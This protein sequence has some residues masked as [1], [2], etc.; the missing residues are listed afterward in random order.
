LVGKV[1]N[2]GLVEVPMGISLRD[3]IYEVGGGIP[4]GRAFKAVQTGGPS[5]GCIPAQFLELPVDFEHLEEAGSIMGSGG[6]IV[7]DET[8]CMVDVA[9]Y[10][11]DF[12]KDESCGKCTPCREGIAHMLDIMTCITE[13]RGQMSDLDA[14]ESLALTIK[15]ASLCGLGQTAPNPV[16]STLKYFR[17]EYVAHIQDKHCPAGV[18]STLVRGTCVNACPAGVDIPS[19]V[20]LVAQGRYAEALEIH[21]Q[22][23]PFALVCGRVCPAFCEDRCRRAELNQPI[24]IRQ[25]KRFMADHEIAKPWTPKREAP[26]SEKVAVIGAGPGGLTAA[27]R[28]AQKGYPVTVFEALPVAGGMLIVGIP[29]YRLPP[30]ILNIEIDN[31]RRAGVEIK[32]NTA[33]GKD[34]SLDDL[35]RQGYKAII[36]AIGAHKSRKLGIS[37]ED[38][39]GVYPGTQ[40]LRDIALDNAPDLTGKRI[41]VVGGGD[42]AIDAVRSAWRLGATEVHLV[43]R[44][45][46][47]DMPAYEEEIEAAEEEGVQFHF[48]TNP[49]RV[50]GNGRM[51]GVEIIRQELTEFDTSGRR[52]PKAIAG[53]EFVLDVD[54]LIPAIGQDP[55]L[56]GLEDEG[57]ETDRGRTLIVHDGLATNKAGVF[58]CG[59]AVTGPATVVQAIGTGNLVA[60]QVDHYLRTGEIHRVAVKPGYTVVDQVFDMEEYFKATRPDTP[61]LPVEERRGTFK[62]VEQSFDELAIREEC[63]RCIRCDR[64]W[65]ET[66]DL[67]AVPVSDQVFVIDTPSEEQT[68]E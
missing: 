37:G 42:V 16:L 52:R 8:T 67:E 7:M 59:D 55:E 35:K 53:S 1:N 51:T 24:A 14:L 54:V 3:L 39:E 26:K 57:L 23:N 43:Y 18:C 56:S 61:M 34:F 27:L 62:E 19:Y 63:K 9:R 25:I 2:T 15:N 36:L 17:D 50:L 65:L 58:A 11:L 4:G 10:F 49:T 20:A 60:A 40:F 47:K 44:R 66:L 31:I 21:R 28:L 32:L 41:A 46:R 6:M 12:L 45:T 48:L 13:G 5:G 22:R 68:A 30:D 29:D 38:L 33:L 64:E